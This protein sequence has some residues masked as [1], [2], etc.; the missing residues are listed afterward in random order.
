MRMILGT[1]I[2]KKTRVANKSW[3]PNADADSYEACVDRLLQ[4]QPATEGSP[5]DVAARIENVM[6]EGLALT[7]PR[8]R[9]KPERTP[10]DKEIRRLVEERRQLRRSAFLTVQERA[11]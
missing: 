11:E 3:G 4:E 5:S 7:C 2:E 8:V 6:V 1:K 10:E 9:R